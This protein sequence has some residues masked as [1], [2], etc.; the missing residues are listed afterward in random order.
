MSADFAGDPAAAERL[1]AR[2]EQEQAAPLS[3]PTLITL[4][5][6][7]AEHVSWLWPARLPAGKLVVLDGD[8][9]VGKS[10]LSVDLAARLSTGTSWPDGAPCPTG[11]VIVLSAEDGL[12]D[13]IRPRLDAAGADPARVHALT[14]VRYFDA[15]GTLSS[16][17]VTLADARLI[18]QAV[19]KVGARLVIVDV[20]MAYLPG[21]VDSHRDQDIRSVLSELAALAE[22]TGCCI[23]LLRHLNKAPGGNPLYRGGGSIGIVGAARAAMLAATDPDDDNR[24]VLAVTKSNLAAMPSALGY[25][26]VDSPDHGCARV[27][28]LGATDHLA[29]ELLGRH[30]ADDDRTERDE[31]AEWLVGYLNDHG[32]EVKAGDAIK[33]AGQDGIAKTTLTRARQRA[34]V[35]SVKAGMSGGWVW[36]MGPRRSARAPVAMPRPAATAMTADRCV[37]RAGPRHEQ[38]PP[39]PSADH[40]PVRPGCDDRAP[41]ARRVRGLQRVPNPGP[42]RHRRLHPG[43]PPRRH[44]PGLPAADDP[45]TSSAAT[46]ELS[47]GDPVTVSDAPPRQ[48]R[49][50]AC[51]EPMA[52]VETE[53]LSHPTCPPWPPNRMPSRAELAGTR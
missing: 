11:D 17:S 22:R 4:S 46:P 41:D 39:A 5:T 28:W 30:E 9:A 50:V 40:R 37:R 31:A 43:R 23:L 21:Q 13:T 16:R 29:G 53:W 34:G 47:R 10:T 8:P 19:V 38:Q 33:A 45:L 3:G 48:V 27:E 25:R 6:V 35:V 24:R 51:C 52:L 44:L 18:E 20:L 32:G 1:R 14:E 7:A 26:L 2:R 49:C 36:K 42:A 12:A 15:E